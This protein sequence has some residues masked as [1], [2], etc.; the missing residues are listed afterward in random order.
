VGGKKPVLRY[1]SDLQGRCVLRG[2]FRYFVG[3]VSPSVDCVSRPVSAGLLTWPVVVYTT[4][5]AIVTGAGGLW[6]P[7]GMPKRDCCGAVP[8]D[9]TK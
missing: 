6:V 5:A 9:P 3:G 2:F 4:K 8:T 1:R 7:L